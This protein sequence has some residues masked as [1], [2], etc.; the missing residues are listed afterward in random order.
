MKRK[1]RLARTGNAFVTGSTRRQA[2]RRRWRK[3]RGA[4]R[5]VGNANTGR[6]APAVVPRRELLAAGRRAR[7][8]QHTRQTTLLNARECHRWKRRRVDD[9][10]QVRPVEAGASGV[11]DCGRKFNDLQRASVSKTHRPSNARHAQGLLLAAYGNDSR[12]A[13]KPTSPTRSRLRARHIAGC[14]LTITSST[15]RLLQMVL[16]D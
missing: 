1:K 2:G 6:Y 14:A 5:V 12:F 16:S 8:A 13:F 11:Y 4:S 7:R 3:S 15:V 9:A 10:K